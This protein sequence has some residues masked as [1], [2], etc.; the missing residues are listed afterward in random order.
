[1]CLCTYLPSGA[2]GQTSGA[3]AS[4]VGT[5]PLPLLALLRAIKDLEELKKRELYLS[6]FSAYKIKM[7]KFKSLLNFY[8]KIPIYQLMCYKCKFHSKSHDFLNWNMWEKYHGRA[9]KSFPGG[10]SYWFRIHCLVINAGTE[11]EED[12]SSNYRQLE[13][14]ANAKSFS[15]NYKY[16]FLI[17][18]LNWTNCSFVLFCF[19]TG[20]QIHCCISNM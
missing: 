10:F 2:G 17:L 20:W 5:L 8:L 14:E 3:N 12:W 9:Y 11:V 16:S 18:Y 1:M 19:E 7:T 15:D 13:G 4:G 6:I